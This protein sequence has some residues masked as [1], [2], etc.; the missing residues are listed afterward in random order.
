MLGAPSEADRDAATLALLDYGFS[1]Y[2]RRTPVRAGEPVDRVAIADRDVE[3][4][5]APRS[6]RPDH[7]PQ[8]PVGRD[9]GRGTGRGRGAGRAGE[10]LG[11]IVVSVDGEAAGR[12]ALIATASADAASLLERYDAAIPGAASRRLGARGRRP[13]ADLRR[14]RGALGPAAMIGAPG[15]YAE[16]LG[17]GFATHDE[18]LA[19]LARPAAALAGRFDLF[20]G[21]ALGLLARR[22]PGIALIRRERGT[23]PALAVCALPPARRRAF[24]LELVRRP[25]PASAWRRA[26]GR[27]WGAAG[28]GA[29]AAPGGGRGADDDRLGSATSTPPR[30]GLDRG[31]VHHVPWALCETGTTPP[32]A[33][34]PGSRAVFASGRTA[35]DWPTLFAAADG[36]AW[37]L[38]VAC[39]RRDLPEVRRLA[40]GA[41]E[42]RCEIPWDEHDRDPARERRVR[43]RA[44]RSRAQ[45]RPR[46]ADVGGRERGPGGGERRPPARG[47]R[48]RRRDRAARRRRATRSACGPRSTPCSP[49]RG[50]GRRSATLRS[51]GRARGPTPTTSTRLRE[52]IAAALGL[53]PGVPG[54][55]SLTRERP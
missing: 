20:R 30:Y 23:L 19:R 11:A 17:A 40:G 7:G 25:P 41:A 31:R 18:L 50:D 48:G 49:T 2:H 54:A 34:S 37:E 42:I 15:F 36:A 1:L 52:L 28:R 39:S 33:I 24:V 12:T 45:R 44:R 10:R 38:T 43:D 5:L 35:C 16:H 8:G 9:P 6:R 51:T 29:A 26:L 47:L 14:R 22:G 53:A 4:V 32:A 27:L 21:L 13:R 55:A 3:V 46:A